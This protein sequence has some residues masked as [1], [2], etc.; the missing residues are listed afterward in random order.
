M[1]NN[2]SFKEQEVLN[3]ITQEQ[4]EAI[5]AYAMKMAVGKGS[6]E[7]KRVP[8]KETLSGDKLYAE[9]TKMMHNM[10]IPAH[11]KGYKYIREAVVMAY[12][13]WNYVEQVTKV[14][15]P[16][17]AKKYST[18]IN[19]V[20]RAIRDAIEYVFDKGNLDYVDIYNISYSSKKGKSTNSQFLASVADYLKQ[21]GHS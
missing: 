19:R 14:L 20:E 6:S 17:I 12:Q 10:G 8:V 3:S 21:Y 5:A 4:W 9:V 7:E 11:I 16:T 2:F 1:N 18:T 15:Y 13:D